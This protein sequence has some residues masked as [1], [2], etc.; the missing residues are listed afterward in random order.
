MKL[1]LPIETSQVLGENTPVVYAVMP[2]NIAGRAHLDDDPY[3]LPALFTDRD[4]AQEFIDNELWCACGCEW[5]I[6]EAVL[7]TKRD[8]WNFQV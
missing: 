8:S 6:E 2:A 7:T 5:G 3:A 4:T 1:L